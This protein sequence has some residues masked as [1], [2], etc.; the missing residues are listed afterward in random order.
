MQQ[1]A[2]GK[3]HALLLTAIDQPSGWEKAA[4]VRQRRDRRS[5]RSGLRA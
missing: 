5:R 3:R 1:A 4:A 2:L